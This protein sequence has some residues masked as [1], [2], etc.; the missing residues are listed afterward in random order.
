[1][2]R[3]LLLTSLV[4]TTVAT[5]GALAASYTAGNLV[6]S[7]IGTGAAVLNG[8]ATA[9]F[10]DEYT[11][12]GSNF[13]NTVALPTS[14]VGTNNALT[15]GGTSTSQGQLTLS[16]DGKYLGIFGYDAPVGLASPSS[17]ASNR[18]RTIGRISGAGGV[19]TTTRFEAAGTTPRAATPIDDDEWY[20]TSDG[21]A[22]SPAPGG[23]RYVPA[24]IT[25]GT[26]LNATTTNIR[27]ANIFNGQLYIGASTGVGGDFRGVS[28]VG[29]GLPTAAAAFALLPGMG[30][31]NGGNTDSTY[32][33][34]FSD[35]NTVYVTDDD[36]TAPASGGVAKWTYNGSTWAKQWTVNATGAT[37]ARSIAGRIQP[38]GAIEL[39][40]IASNTTTDLFTI[41]DTGS[42]IPAAVTLASA[43][44][45]T[46]FRGVEFAPVPE[47]TTL[48][49]IAG[50]LTLIRRGRRN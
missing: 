21:G 20:T 50:A 14:A 48:G 27:T 46:V 29:T 16:P 7:R 44:T 42:G 19:L 9:V 26:L 32:D 34:F 18:G 40:A 49:L 35:A 8:N 4:S 38:T 22:G 24:G 39:Y 30:V 13:A 17:A 25:S 31:S 47:P 2:R 43:P 1:M 3:T 45:N 28:S 5:S 11:T 33:F 15:L 6:I 10:I 12:A 36:T 41:L 23:L 37:G